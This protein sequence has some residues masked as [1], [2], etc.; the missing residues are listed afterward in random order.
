MPGPS[1]R[2]LLPPPHQVWE[3]SAQLLEA[4]RLHGAGKRQGAADC[5]RAADLDV[6]G[7]WFKKVV[8]PYD[9]DIHGARP[10]VLYPPKLPPH[11]RSRP[12]MLGSTDKRRILERDGF[13]CRFCEMPVAPKETIRLIARTYPNDARWTDVASEQHRFFQAANLQYDHIVPH[14]RGGEST[15]DNMV[16]TCAVCNYGR[17]SSTLEESLLLDPREF[18]LRKSDW[19]GLQ[20]FLP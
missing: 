19:D 4:V 15:V 14:S 16:V 8:G 13:H 2:C 10:L 18:P 6:L 7:A 20:A 11:E 3:A 9:Q 12:R 1:R 5:F 17:M